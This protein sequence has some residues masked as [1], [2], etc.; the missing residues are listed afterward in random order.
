MDT[1]SILLEPYKEKQN[2]QTKNR[3]LS[4]HMTS[5]NYFLKGTIFKYSHII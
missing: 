1:N 3:T 4:T 2:K 5:F